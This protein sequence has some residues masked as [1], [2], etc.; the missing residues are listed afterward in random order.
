MKFLDGESDSKVLP[1]DLIAKLFHPSSGSVSF[2]PSS[3]IERVNKDPKAFMEA[4]P[5]ND[6]IWLHREF[7]RV[8]TAVRDLGDTSMSPSIPFNCATGLF[9]TNWHGG[10]N[11]VQ[12]REALKGLL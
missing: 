6:D 11:E 4:C 5:T 8:G 10:Q 1:K 7:F 12:L 9:Q 2:I 3:L